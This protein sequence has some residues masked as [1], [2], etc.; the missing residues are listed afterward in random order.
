MP[1]T[2]SLPGTL[3]SA[4]VQRELH[5]QSELLGSQACSRNTKKPVRLVWSGSGAGSPK[6]RVWKGNGVRLDRALKV[7]VKNRVSWEVMGRFE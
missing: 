1:G 5:V 6:R 4:A 3:G 7:I 2:S